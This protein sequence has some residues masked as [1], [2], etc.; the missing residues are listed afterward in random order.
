MVAPQAAA[1]KA[2]MSA[3]SWMTLDV[4]LPAPWPALLSMRAI[5]GLLCRRPPHFTSWCCSSAVS[6][7]ECSGGTLHACAPRQA[8]TTVCKGAE[9]LCGGVHLTRRE[10]LIE[11]SASGQ[12][13]VL[14]RSS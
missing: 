7:Y 6:L 4:G 11:I 10:G 3:T 1:A 2:S 14:L 13:R 8:R 12:I 9:A 5:S